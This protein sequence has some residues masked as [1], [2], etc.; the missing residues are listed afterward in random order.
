MI[1]HNIIASRK[2][3]KTHHIIVNAEGIGHSTSMAKRIEAA[4]GIET[5][6]TILGYLQRGGNPTCKDRFYAS[7]MGAYSADILCEGKSNRVVAYKHGEFVDYDIEEALNMTK[8]ID[9]YQFD[10][11]KKLSR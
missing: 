4:T 3:G 9:E 6:A 11:C 1:N 2:R 7:I 10:I 5:R 8:S